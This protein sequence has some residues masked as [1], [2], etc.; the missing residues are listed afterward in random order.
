[1]KKIFPLISCL[2]LLAA[3]AGPQEPV[4][5]YTFQFRTGS[6]RET[7]KDEL[8]QMRAQ[9]LEDKPDLIRAEI[10]RPDVPHP[11]PVELGFADGKLR[12]VTYGPESASGGSVGP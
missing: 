11:V 5:E 2:L 10:V 6:S 3:C 4:R 7:V 1:M 12:S 8:K 9:I